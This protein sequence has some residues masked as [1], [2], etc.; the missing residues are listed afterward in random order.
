VG[1]ETYR[2]EILKRKMSNREIIRAF[3][4]A[5]NLGLKTQSYNMIGLPYETPELIEETITLNK[6]ILPDHIAFYVFNPYINTELWEVC[7]KEG[8]LSNRKSNRFSPDYILNQ[9]SLTEEEFIEC[10][11]KFSKLSLD[12]QIKSDYPILYYPSKLVIFLLGKNARIFL[13]NTKRWLKKMK[14]IK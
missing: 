5:R 7:K 3:E 10:H 12:Q 6:T 11:Q 2:K 1:N 14:V 8:F 9:E 4:T 13:I